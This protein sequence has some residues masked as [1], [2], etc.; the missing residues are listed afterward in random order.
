MLARFGGIAKRRGAGIRRSGGTTQA[1][2]TLRCPSVARLCPEGIPF[3]A[4]GMPA[5]STLGKS[6]R[7]IV[8]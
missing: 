1:T 7:K 3:E 6:V 2:G 8:C 5:T 4:A